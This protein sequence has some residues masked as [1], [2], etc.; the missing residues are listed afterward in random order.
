M[1][2]AF[3]HGQSLEID[4]ETE[5]KLLELECAHKRFDDATHR[6][7]QRPL[8][9]KFTRDAEPSN[10]AGLACKGCCWP[11]ALV[12]AFERRHCAA[13]TLLLPHDSWLRRTP[14]NE[15]PK[16]MPAR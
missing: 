8:L 16:V 1:T 12:F 6:F 14:V 13:A 2:I 9:K 15:S 3:G 7:P 10:F 11:A 5:K 4:Y